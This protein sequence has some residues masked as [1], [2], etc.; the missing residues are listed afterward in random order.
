MFGA[1]GVFRVF[2]SWGIKVAT[3]PTYGAAGRRGLTLGCG[4]EARAALPRLEVTRLEGF[5]K[6]QLNAKLGMFP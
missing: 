1:F 6:P 3:H 2:E 4:V 5:P